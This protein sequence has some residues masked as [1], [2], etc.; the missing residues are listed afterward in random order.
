M[1]QPKN[2]VPGFGLID[3]ELLMAVA[4]ES[5]GFAGECYWKLRLAPITGY[6]LIALGFVALLMRKC[7][8]LVDIELLTSVLEVDAPMTSDE[9]RDRSGSF[10]PNCRST[11]LNGGSLQADSN[12]A[13]QPV[14]CMD[15]GADWVDEYI[16]SGYDHLDMSSAAG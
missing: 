10:C 7:T 4:L 5:V 9:Y 13:W 6:T 1:S 11:D 2:A 16:L 12:Y 8:T 15:C 3:T 14:S